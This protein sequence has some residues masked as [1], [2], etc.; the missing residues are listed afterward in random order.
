MI[1]NYCKVKYTENDIIKG[2]NNS[3]LLLENV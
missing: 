1:F 2:N 3:F